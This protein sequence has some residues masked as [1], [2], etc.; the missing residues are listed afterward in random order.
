MKREL[1]LDAEAIM[2]ICSADSVKMSFRKWLS[3]R[4]KKRV[5]CDVII[6][7]LDN[8]SM[9]LI[10]RKISLIQIWEITKPLVFSEVYQKARDNMIFRIIDR[11]N[12]L[13]FMKNGRLYLQFLESNQDLQN[14]IVNLNDHLSKKSVKEITIKDV[15]IKVL[16]AESHPMTVK[17]IYNKIVEQNLYSFNAQNPISILRNT[18]NYN[19]DN[20]KYS[21]KNTNFCFHF[22]EDISG[23]KV[24]SLLGKTKINS[25][26][27]QCFIEI[28]ILSDNYYHEIRIWDDKVE[29]EFRNW[30]SD[31][32]YPKEVV[33]QYCKIATY[34]FQKCT[35]WVRETTI[36]C[37]NQIEAIRKLIKSFNGEKDY[38]NINSKQH[39]QFVD[40][41]NVLERFYL[42]KEE[43]KNSYL[44]SDLINKQ[45][46]Q[47]NF[48]DSSF[49]QIIDLEEGKTGIRKILET[50]FQKLYG[51]SNINILWEATQHNL[52]MFLNDNAIN[53]PEDLWKFMEYAFSNEYILNNPHIWRT[54]PDYP[55]SYEVLIINLARHLGGIVTREQ[56]DGYFTL[57]NQKSPINS[58]ILRHNRLMFYSEKQFI[59]SEL[60]EL[61]EERCKAIAKSLD[62]LFES[63][64][65]PY[66]VLRDVA[67]EWFLTLPIIKGGIRW[68]PL[69]IQ[70]VLRSRPSIGYRVIFSGL[71]GQ[72]LDTIG[73]AIVPNQSDIKSFADV[74]YQ[75][76][77]EKGIL[78]EKMTTENFRIM[79]RKVGMLDGNELIFNLHKSLKDCRFAFTD[80][81]KMVKILER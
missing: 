49:D 66:V 74:V 46:S 25:S 18:I 43:N 79:L 55:Q 2:P 9:Q 32:L 41:L 51:Y 69:L 48:G 53:N 64:K 11:K 78:G 24:Y 75:Y 27:K 42:C 36:D 73:A 59:L 62:K 80:E 12:Y 23:E 70:E 4:N 72:A 77:F 65:V 68:T 63:E 44:D 14:E 56:I 39:R 54:K 57:I 67:D 38:L 60:L 47:E 28:N 81:N 50:H 13:S 58:T 29:L 30:L 61:S 71:D 34:N 76:C 5:D 3:N 22:E 1:N 6:S 45:I 16:M 10:K 15:V 26:H 52:A 8:V 40:L 31:E 37:N 35:D 7:S 33:D 20:S 19:S 17:E 21:R